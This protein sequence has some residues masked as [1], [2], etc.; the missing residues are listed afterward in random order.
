MKYIKNNEETKKGNEVLIEIKKQIKV[1]ENEENKRIEY[2]AKKKD[3]MLQMRKMR[4]EIKFR[5]YKIF[6]EL[7]IIFIFYREKQNERQRLI[8]AQV[9][10]LKLLKNKEDERINKQ[11]VE[12]QVRAENIE[13][14]KREKIAQL[15]VNI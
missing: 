5:F 11:I 4:E 14:E 9:E 12:A 8:D 1:K 10:K 6:F 15:K 13:K 3:D 2:F 7:F